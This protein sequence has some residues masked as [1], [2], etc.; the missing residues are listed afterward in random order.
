MHRRLETQVARYGF[1]GYWMI[2]DTGCCDLGG[3]KGPVIFYRP[4][5]TNS[6]F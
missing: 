2:L 1:A 4:R 5:R 6:N 3:K